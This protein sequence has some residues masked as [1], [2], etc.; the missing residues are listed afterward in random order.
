MMSHR[1][2][3]PLSCNTLDMGTAN[4]DRLRRK[5]AVPNWFRLSQ[6][7]VRVDTLEETPLFEVQVAQEE[8]PLLGEPVV[9][10]SIVS[11]PPENPLPMA[12]QGDGIE[13][14]RQNM[15]NMDIQFKQSLAGVDAQLTASV[16]SMKNDMN[17]LMESMHEITDK[18]LT[19]TSLQFEQPPKVE[20]PA[21]DPNLVA[22]MDKIGKLEESVQETKRL[23]K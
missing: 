16:V 2:V 10:E 15:A 4:I 7:L 14:L 17:M 19:K 18:L 22:L 1:A 5:E 21:A 11:I 9:E 13:K 6:R 20:I 23:G 8:Q 12:D 3:R